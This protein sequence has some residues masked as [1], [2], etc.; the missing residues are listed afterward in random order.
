MTIQRECRL[1]RGSCTPLPLSQCS[2]LNLVVQGSAESL[3]EGEVCLVTDLSLGPSSSLAV[4]PWIWSSTWFPAWVSALLLRLQVAHCGSSQLW[5]CKPHS[6]AGR[7]SQDEPEHLAP[8]LS[9]QAQGTTQGGV[10]CFWCLCF[11]YLQHSQLCQ[12]PG[13]VWSYWKGFCVEGKT[14]QVERHVFLSS[15][16]SRSKGKGGSRLIPWSSSTWVWLIQM[17]EI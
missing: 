2:V 5:V 14:A 15:R 7:S 11:R 13:H 6:Q 12:V 17:G 4:F 1:P 3:H 16:L 10:G 9:L 8:V